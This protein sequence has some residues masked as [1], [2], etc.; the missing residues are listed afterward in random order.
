MILYIYVNVNYSL[1]LYTKY[2]EIGKTKN[3]NIHVFLNN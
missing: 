2:T 3:F 1:L